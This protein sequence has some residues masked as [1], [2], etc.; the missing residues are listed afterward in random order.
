MPERRVTV[1]APE[2]LHAR[3]AAQFVKAVADSGAAVTIGR[4]AGGDP[5]DARSILAVLT[6]DVRQG[7]E[8]VLRADGTGA[9]AA[10]ERL[11]G[12]LAGA[13]PEGEAGDG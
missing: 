5:V 10:L 12:L 2:G 1:A 7:E 4:P 13:V 3:P 9:V 8:V 6:L 11:A